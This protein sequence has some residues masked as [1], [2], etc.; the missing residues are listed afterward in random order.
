LAFDDP[1]PLR[2]DTVHPLKSGADADALK[3]TAVAD[4]GSKPPP[5]GRLPAEH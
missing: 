4:T 1:D 2:N 5:T 3:G